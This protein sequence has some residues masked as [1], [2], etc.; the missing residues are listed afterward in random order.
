MPILWPLKVP[1]RGNAITQ[2]KT[3]EI[4]HSCLI[5]YSSYHLNISFPSSGSHFN[6][7]ERVLE[8]PKNCFVSTVTL[9]NAFVC[10]LF[11]ELRNLRSGVI[12]FSVFCF[13]ASL[14][15][16]GK[17]ERANRERAWSQAKNYAARELPILFNT[18]KK[19]LLKSSYPK[20][21]LLNFR[22]QKNSGTQKNPSIILVTWNPEY[23]PT[24][25]LFEGFIFGGAYIRRDLCTEG[26]L[27][28]K[29]DW[30][31]L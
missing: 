14:A 10:T 8:T 18:R 17:K 30:F 20:K 11:A 7:L 16:E 13:F 9:W 21:Y 26:N 5:V 2:R 19:S 3:L 22:T 25:A 23:P 6:K 4:E 28:F 27:R 29:I 15:R 24:R 31:S 1:E 12:F